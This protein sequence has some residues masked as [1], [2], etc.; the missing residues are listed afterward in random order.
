MRL[1]HL[2]DFMSRVENGMIAQGELP[3]SYGVSVLIFSVASLPML[4]SY[5]SISW[6]IQDIGNR[7]GFLA[8]LSIRVI[9]LTALHIWLCRKRQGNVDGNT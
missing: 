6:D 4:F 1:L 5:E 9:S 3:H 8:G 7:Q 2:F